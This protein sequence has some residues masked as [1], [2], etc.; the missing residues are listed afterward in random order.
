[1]R[2]VD[3]VAPPMAGHLHPVLGIAA[4]LDASIMID[5]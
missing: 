4:R 1:M 2:Y 5:G 3:L